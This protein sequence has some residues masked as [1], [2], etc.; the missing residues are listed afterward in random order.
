MPAPSLFSV[1]VIGLL[2]G[3]AAR[4]LVGGRRSLFGSLVAGV[5]GAMLGTTVAGL[6]DLPMTGLL[7]VAMAALAGAAALLS[8]AELVFRR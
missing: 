3:V 1:V 8:A 5:L 7:A 4:R 6:F 2:A